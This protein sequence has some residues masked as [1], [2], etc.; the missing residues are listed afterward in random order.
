MSDVRISAYVTKRR[1]CMEGIG[2]T[3]QVPASVFSNTLTAHVDDGE[4]VQLICDLARAIDLSFVAEPDRELVIA[5]R[6]RLAVP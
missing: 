4:A 2:V 1:R 6:E 5:V 3:V